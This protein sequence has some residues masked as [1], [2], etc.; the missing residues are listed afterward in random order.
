MLPEVI[1]I[2]GGAFKYSDDRILSISHL[3]QSCGTIWF[4]TSFRIIK[5]V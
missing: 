3:A 5:I 2:V 4:D 1:R